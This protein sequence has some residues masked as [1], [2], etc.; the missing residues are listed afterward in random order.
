M[1]APFVFLPILMATGMRL[2]VHLY[3]LN[4]QRCQEIRRKLEARRGIIHAD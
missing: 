4:E 2:L 3:P 1:R